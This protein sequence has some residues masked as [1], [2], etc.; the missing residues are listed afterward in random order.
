MKTLGLVGGTGWA[1]SLEYYR[2]INELTNSKLGGLN[3]SHCVLY[4]VN[5]AEIDKCNKN[6]DMDGVYS[7]IYDAAEKLISI[8]ADY[9]V[10]CANTLH[11]FA[12]KLQKQIPVPIVHIAEATAKH[13]Q[14]Q[15]ISKVGLLGTKQ[16]MSE[17]F[18]KSTLK[19][20]GISTIVPNNKD[21][22]FI[23]NTILLEL[24]NNDFK[25]ESKAEFLRIMKNMQEQG[26]EAII[27]GCTE[28]PLLIKQS[29]FELPLINTLQ[30]HA[31]AAVEF[32][33]E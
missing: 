11:R 20:Y 21:M 19:D 29:D 4:S 12:E 3:Y 1:S 27:L 22:D 9:I 13:I 23:N 7:I 33:I 10:L 30:I 8:G 31:E 16:T 14:K 28:I 18:Y 6:N 17:D 25:P 15:N 5:Y 26:A 32:A 24:F 2:L